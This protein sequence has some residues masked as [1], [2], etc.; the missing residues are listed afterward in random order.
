[1]LPTVLMQLSLYKKIVLS[2]FGV[3]HIDAICVVGALHPV[4]PRWLR[5]GNVERLVTYVTGDGIVIV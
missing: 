5:E 4:A 3:V 2:L 1:M